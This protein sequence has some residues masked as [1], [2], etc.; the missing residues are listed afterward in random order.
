MKHKNHFNNLFLFLM[1][2]F[3]I[4]IQAGM[5]GQGTVDKEAK[6]FQFERTKEKNYPL[7]SFSDLYC[8]FSF[9]DQKE[10]P[11]E[12]VG[13][14]KS[15]EKFLLTDSDIVYL[16]QGKDNGLK[17]GEVFLVVEIGSR[18]KSPYKKEIKGYLL[19]KKG[20]VRILDVL[21]ETSRAVIEKACGKV[22]VG[23]HL[24]PFEEKETV[25][26]RDLG[27]PDVIQKEEGR[28]GRI[29]YLG[30]ELV[31]IGKEDWAL[32]DMGLESG[33]QIGDQLIIYKKNKLNEGIANSVVIDVQSQ[34]CTIKILSCK[35]VIKEGYWVKKRSE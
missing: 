29:I 15:E 11:M 33:I 20:R 13:S 34:T 10:V 3:L 18:I 2:V 35:D 14:E 9:I 28:E 27:F 4:L 16:N 21:N 23:Q 26:G 19:L 25:M 6:T 8:S 7:I 30:E 22:N 12:I 1:A 24:I 5:S 31:N 32:I 17:E